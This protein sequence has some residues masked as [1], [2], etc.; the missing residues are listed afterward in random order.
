MAGGAASGVL[1]GLVAMPIVEASDWGLL[2]LGLA[3][4]IAAGAILGLMLVLMLHLLLSI[5]GAASMGMY[6][7]VGA[8]AGFLVGLPVPP[9]GSGSLIGLFGGLVAGLTFHRLSFGRIDGDGRARPLRQDWVRLGFAA[10]AAG[11]AAAATVWCFLAGADFLRTAAN[12]SRFDTGR[13]LEGLFGAL[14]LGVLGGIVIGLPVHAA[15]AGGRIK[16]RLAYGGMGALIGA[17]IGIPFLFVWLIPAEA[18][19][20]SGL[21]GLVGGIVFHRLGVRT[22]PGARLDIEA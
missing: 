22:E 14:I 9:L 5:L 16:G 10:L 3:M 8:I 12:A 20:V 11:P 18:P 2:G 1:F 19:L 7:L 6:G 15:L 17:V 21:A 4:G 13:S